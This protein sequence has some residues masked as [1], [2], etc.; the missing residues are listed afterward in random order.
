MDDYEMY[1]IYIKTDDMA[2]VAQ[3]DIYAYTNSKEIL[4]QF[5][6]T[7]NMDKFYIKKESFTKEELNDLYKTHMHSNLEK[8]K[9]SFRDNCYHYHEASIPI[10]QWERM[11][12]DMASSMVIHEKI[13]EHVWTDIYPLKKKYYNALSKLL[14]VGL[15]HYITEG[16]DDLWSETEGKMISLSLPC[17]FDYCGELF[18]QEG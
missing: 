15:H 9:V 1:L 7:R 14:Y 16:G 12:I 4:K 2:D 17:L 18:P 13:Y 3:Y 6:E 5:K 11:K 8:Y 10:T